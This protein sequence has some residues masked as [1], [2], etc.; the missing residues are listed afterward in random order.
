MGLCRM[1]APV[2]SGETC[3]L[4]SRDDCRRIQYHRSIRSSIGSRFFLFNEIGQLL[5]AKLTPQGYE[6][7]SK[8]KIL[9]PTG[10]A[11]GRDVVWSHPAFAN[12]SV[13]VRNDKEIACFSLAAE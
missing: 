13:Y 8:A 5:I 3:V 2:P 11:F 4:H 12:K 10:T 1:V 7:I 9:D 6:E